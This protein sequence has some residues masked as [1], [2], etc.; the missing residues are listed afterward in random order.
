MVFVGCN[1][2]ETAMPRVGRLPTTMRHASYPLCNLMAETAMPRVGRHPTTMRHA[3]YPLCTLMAETAMPRVGRQLNPIGKAS[4]GISQQCKN[5]PNEGTSPGIGRFDLA[6]A[7]Y[8]FLYF[9]VPVA[10]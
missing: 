4:Q 10:V 3:S 5:N 1:M 2:A 6:D 8:C 9:G 7:A